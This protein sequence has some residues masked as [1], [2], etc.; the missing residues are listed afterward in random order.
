MRNTTF[1]LIFMPNGT[2]RKGSLRNCIYFNFLT[3]GVKPYT[4][5]WIDEKMPDDVITFC[6]KLSF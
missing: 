2:K 4:I 1:T 3:S 5:A 6:T